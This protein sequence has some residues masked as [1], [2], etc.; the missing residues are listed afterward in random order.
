MKKMK[1]VV[2][3]VVYSPHVYVC[4]GCGHEY[5]PEI[6][7]EDSDIKPELD[8]KIYL[9]IGLAL[10]VRSKIWIYRCKIRI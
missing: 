4:S 8:L 2:P 10:I 1:R 3:K 5:N 6:G 7:D 9:K